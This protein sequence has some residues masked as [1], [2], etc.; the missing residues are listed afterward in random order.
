MTHHFHFAIPRGASK[1]SRA[2]AL[3]HIA[4]TFGIAGKVRHVRSEATFH[5]YVIDH[6]VPA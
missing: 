5:L 4:E 1:A 2:N 3:R 6:E